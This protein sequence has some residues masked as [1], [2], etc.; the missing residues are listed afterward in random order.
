VRAGLQVHAELALARRWNRHFT[1]FDRLTQ[2]RRSD[3]NLGVQV[4]ASWLP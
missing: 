4:E 1:G 2:A 3:T